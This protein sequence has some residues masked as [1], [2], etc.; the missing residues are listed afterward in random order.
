MAVLRVERLKNGMNGKPVWATGA[1][2]L[3]FFYKEIAKLRQWTC[4]AA[5]A[6]GLF[7]L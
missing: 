3:R 5:A 7:F 2:F 4:G 1:I 6:H